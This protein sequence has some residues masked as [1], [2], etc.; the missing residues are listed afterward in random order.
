MSKTLLEPNET[1]ANAGAGRWM[2]VI[3]NNETNS[4]EEV[5][6]ILMTATAC[7]AEEAEVEMLEAHMLGKASVHFASKSECDEVAA[8]IGSI[9]VKTEVSK[10]WTD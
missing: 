10:E 4:M 5:V 2:V 3:F 1:I 7:T 9:G 6:E 8:V